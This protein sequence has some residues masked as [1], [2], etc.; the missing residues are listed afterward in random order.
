MSETG[1]KQKSKSNGI[2]FPDVSSVEVVTHSD[3]DQ[4]A[5]CS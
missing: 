5:L 1:E 3:K 2:P 4:M